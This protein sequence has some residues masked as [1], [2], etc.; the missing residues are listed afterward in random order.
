[1]VVTHGYENRVSRISG[2]RSP[3]SLSQSRRLKT[4]GWCQ[5]VVATPGSFAYP[6]LNV[7]SSQTINAVLQGLTEAG[8]DGIIQV[9]TGGADYFAG[10]AVR[11]RATGAIAFAKYVTEVAQ[12]YPITVALHADHCPQDALS[13][14]VLPLIEASEEEVR[15]GRGPLLQSNMWDGSAVPLEENIDIAADPLPRMRNINSILEIEIEIE[16]EIED[17]D[18]DR[19]RGRRRRGRRRAA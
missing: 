10:H 1:M 19:G 3:V 12:S 11:A 9:N 16:I 8:S 13:T 4:H 17:G 2:L 5:P 14:F 6:S 18:R 15:A 7:S